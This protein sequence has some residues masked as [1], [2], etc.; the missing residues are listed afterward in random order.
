MG[1]LVATAIQRLIGGGSSIEA[2]FTPEKCRAFRTVGER[3]LVAGSVDLVSGPL[4]PEGAS[5]TGAAD[6]PGGSGSGS[7]PLQRL[8]EPLAHGH[9]PVPG[10]RQPPGGCASALDES[11]ETVNQNANGRLKDISKAGDRR[12]RSAAPGWIVATP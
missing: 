2:A 9:G 4:P 11:Q 6:R 3:G 12:C 5:T 1:C 10:N 8:D 7:G